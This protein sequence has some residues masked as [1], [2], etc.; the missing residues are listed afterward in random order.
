MA[1]TSDLASKLNKLIQTKGAIAS[2]IEEMGV[3]IPTDA[4]FSEYANLIQQISKGSS[5]SSVRLGQIPEGCSIRI[6]QLDGFSIFVVA[7]HNYE[8]DLNGPGR[9]LLI[10]RDPF[11]MLYWNEDGSAHVDYGSCDLDSYLNNEYL[12][13]YFDQSIIEMMGMTKFRYYSQVDNGVLI[14]ERSIFIPSITEFGVARSDG[15]SEGESLNI[16]FLKSIALDGKRTGQWTRSQTG[17]NFRVFIINQTSLV[18][19]S[20]TVN[21]YYYPFLPCF[22]LPSDFHVYNLESETNPTLT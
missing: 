10:K 21:T 22:T 16:G 15:L 19:S 11:I 12:T 18:G 14:S 9:T 1:I 4:P 13:Q 17:S 20:A 2:S 3:P 7:K 8:P 5:S 6:A